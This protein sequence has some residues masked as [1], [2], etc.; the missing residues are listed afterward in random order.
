MNVCSPLGGGKDT[1]SKCKA[2]CKLN[3]TFLRNDFSNTEINLEELEVSVVDMQY[4]FILSLKTIIKY[5]LLPVLQQ[6]FRD[7][8]EP[9]NSAV[10]SSSSLLTSIGPAPVFVSSLDLEGNALKNRIKTFPKEHF[11]GASEKELD[12]TEECISISDLLPP[13]DSAT[14]DADEMDSRHV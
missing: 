4:D 11:F 2:V 5:N 12:G 3:L 1:C 9:G 8:Y 13:S 14:T 6:Y 7:Q 10:N